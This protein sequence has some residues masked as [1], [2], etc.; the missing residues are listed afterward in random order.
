MVSNLHFLQSMFA[1][2]GTPFSSILLLLLISSCK[3]SFLLKGLFDN[4]NLLKCLLINLKN[5]FPM[6][7][8]IPFE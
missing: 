8:N 3:L 6:L 2:K 1:L 7:V 5:I 4:S